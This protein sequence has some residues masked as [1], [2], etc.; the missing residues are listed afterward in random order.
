MDALA[1]YRAM[2]ELARQH[3]RLDVKTAERWQEEADIWAKL[4]VN[5]QRAARLKA[6]SPEIWARHSGKKKW[7]F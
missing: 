7:S 5:E 1:R 4:L 6:M 2:A 3:A